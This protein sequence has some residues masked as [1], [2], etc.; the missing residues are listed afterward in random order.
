MLDDAPRHGACQFHRSAIVSGSRFAPS[1]VPALREQLGA[2][3]VTACWRAHGGHGELIHPQCLR[4]ES[5]DSATR[6][7]HS[8]VSLLDFGY[9]I[10]SCASKPRRQRRGRELE[11]AKHAAE[12]IAILRDICCSGPPTT[13]PANGMVPNR[14]QR[15]LE[16]FRTTDYVPSLILVQ[17]WS[18]LSTSR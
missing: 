17:V 10:L 6:R 13:T 2:R 7:P 3:C 4:G 5:V 12:M 16:P 1:R 11:Q 8:F 18:R 14:D 9:A 15:P